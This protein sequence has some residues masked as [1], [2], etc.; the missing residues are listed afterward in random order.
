[1][2]GSATAISVA[3]LVLAPQWGTYRGLSGIDSAL[4]VALA[5]LLLLKSGRWPDRSLGAVALVLFC[6]KVAAEMLTASALFTSDT[7]GHEVVPLA[8]FVGAVVGLSAV[9]G[10]HRLEARARSQ[11]GRGR[12]GPARAAAICLPRTL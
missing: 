1:M 10:Q 2:L 4:F 9:F 12:L 7:P 6:G 3:L 5:A 11:E 8:H